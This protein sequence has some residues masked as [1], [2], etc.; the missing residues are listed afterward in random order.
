MKLVRDGSE[1]AVDA[2]H[3]VFDYRL[4]EDKVQ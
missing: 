2:I 1:Q 4:N 3:E